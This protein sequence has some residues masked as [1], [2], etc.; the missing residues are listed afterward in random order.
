M[1]EQI[2]PCG[3]YWAYCDGNCDKCNLFQRTY[4]TNT[5]NNI[6]FT[7]FNYCSNCEIRIK[8]GKNE[9]D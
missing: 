5:T 1:S 3:M 6:G 8:N 9:I 4:D 7:E 2:R